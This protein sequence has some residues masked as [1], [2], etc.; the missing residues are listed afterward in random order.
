MSIKVSTEKPNLLFS[1]AGLES[2]MKP[3]KTTQC[4]EGS[5]RGRNDRGRSDRGRNEGKIEHWLKRCRLEKMDKTI[6]EDQ[7]TR[8]LTSPVVD[9][10]KLVIESPQN[11]Q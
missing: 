4:I 10:T 5:D 9:V 3:G 1:T 11:P 2:V 7:T 6:P 8:N